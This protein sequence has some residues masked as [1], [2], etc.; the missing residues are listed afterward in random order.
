MIDHHHLDSLEK[1]CQRQLDGMTVNREV[2]AKDTMRLVQD[3]RRLLVMVEAR[4][5]ETKTSSFTQAFDDIFKP[6]A[7]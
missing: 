3:Y 4:T 5:N 1:R 6:A 7:P 2:L